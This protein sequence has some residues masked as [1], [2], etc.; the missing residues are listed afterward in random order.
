MNPSPEP[1]PPIGP[2][3][4][5][6]DLI[7][8]PALRAPADLPIGEA[9]R[10]FAGA[11]AGSSPALVVVDG[12]RPIGIVTPT[13]LLPW[14]GADSPD[15][16]QPLSSLM[17]SPLIVLH[18]DA[19]LEAARELL[20]RAHIGRLGVTDADGS[21]VGLV[22]WS[23][24]ATALSGEPET[25]LPSCGATAANPAGDDPDDPG[26]PQVQRP[27][28]R[29]HDL[30]KTTTDLV[31]D[32]DPA[33]HFT[34]VSERARDLLG[35]EP[36]RLIGRSI[37][38][39]MSPAEAQRVGVQFADIVAA[40]R[41][42]R[43]LEN[44]CLHRDGSERVLSTSGVPLHATN[45]RLI[46][47]RGMCRDL[48]AAYRTAQALHDG[49]G[50][51]R[52]IF[53][54]A[55]VG[56]MLLTG[57]RMLERCNERFAEILGYDS[58]DAMRG[59]SMRALHLD[60]DHFAAF[61][62]E[63]YLSLRFGQ[64]R[65]I[66]YQL[67]RADGSPVWCLLSGRAIDTASP[68]DLGLGVIWTVED[69]TERKAREAELLALNARLA[70]DQTLFNEGPAMVFRWR[71]E[72]GWPVAE[73]SPNVERL[74][75][76]SIADLTAGRV[77]FAD[78]LHLD[79]QARVTAEVARHVAAGAAEY[80][81]FYR[82]RG[83]GGQWLHVYDYTRVLRAADGTVRAYHG[84]LVDLTPQR[85]REEE[86]RALMDGIPDLIF[87][88]DD[89]GRYL[90]CNVAFSGFIGRS[91]SDVL[92]HTDQ[93]LFTPAIAE[94]FRAHDRAMLASGLPHRNEEWVIW[95]DGTRHLLDTLKMPYARPGS[96]VA[97]VLGISRDITEH[98]WQTRDLDRAQ[99]LARV[100]SFFI[101]LVA[102]RTHWSPHLYRILGL[103]VADAAPSDARLLTLVLPGDQPHLAETF[104][105]LRRG[106]LEYT[107]LD[108]RIRRPD[109]EV[110]WLTSRRE[111]TRDEHGVPVRIDGVIQDVTAQR[112][113][114]Q[115][116]AE[117]ETRYRTLFEHMAQPL[118]VVDGDGLIAAV[119]PAFSD[120]LGYPQPAALIGAAPGNLSPRCQPDGEA[121][122][123]K[124]ERMVALARAHGVHRFEWVH[125]RRDGTGVP[126]EVTLNPIL[127]GGR[128]V[129]LASVYDLRD[130][131]RA[132][133]WE[134]RAA[135]VFS[136]TTEGILLT[137]AVGRIVAVNPAFTAITG[138]R[139]DEVQGRRPNV[140]QS[141]RQDRG[142]YQA[143]WR[144]LNE[145]G[146]W[147]GQL[148]NRR[149][150]GELFVEWLSISAIRNPAGQVQSYIGIF[151]DITAAE[152]T[153]EEL[154]HLT[155]HD[156]LTDL[157]NATLFRA[158]L[159]QL[160]RTGLAGAQ[161]VAVL[162][163]NLDGFKHVVSA[164]GHRQADAV[165]VQVAQLLRD[166][167]PAD[168]TL[169]RLG[170]DTFAVGI[171][172]VPGPEAVSEHVARIQALL[173]RG[174]RVEGVGTLAIGAGLGVA[175]CPSDSRDATELL[176][177]ADSALVTAKAGGPGAWAFFRPEMTAR[178]GERL[179]LGQALR[180]AL[181][182]GELVLYLQPQLDLSN[183]LV[184]GAEALIRWRTADGV[185][186]LPQDFMPVVESSDLVWP[187]GRRVIQEAARI[188]ADWQSAGL[189]PV[190]I[191]V[192]VS[193]AMIGG[194][195]LADAIVGAAAAFGIDPRLLGIEVLENV[196][197]GNPE[198]ARTEIAAVRS[199]GVAVAL[200]DFG[201]GYSSL[202]YL[203]RFAVD[204]LKI[205]RAFIGDLRPESEDL[206]IVR[207]TISMAHHLGIQ[208]V[209]EGVESTDQLVRLVSLGC[210]F[211]QGHL[212]GQ[213]MPPEAFA[214]LLRQTDLRL[215]DVPVQDL[216]ARRALLVEDD[217]IQRTMLAAFFRDLG[218]R[219]FA[220][221]SA[222][223]ARER[224]V[225]N[226]VHLLIADYRLPGENGVGLLQHARAHYP[227]VVRVL[228]SASDDPEVI[229]EGI[230][231]GGIFYYLPKPCT[232]AQ[233]ADLCEAGFAL[234]RLLRQAG[235]LVASQVQH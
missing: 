126:V 62:K 46:G 157:P 202:A 108:Y 213:P 139:E 152:R 32:V 218:W 44:R 96:D 181:A 156:L 230:N 81:Q 82:L 200:D 135:T 68:A 120:L 105:R 173:H 134:R 72:P 153:A 42:F 201:T 84:Y 21:L 121:S 197:I 39:L 167:L 234:A 19:T 203:K 90:D 164:Y 186:H 124:A 75:G 165:L 95:S 11:A 175:L 231:L 227:E 36:E 136:A 28:A 125:Q 146:R 191:S 87:F 117:S 144:E 225:H 1:S 148:W 141:G 48:T 14:L 18:A 80:E 56:I 111:L 207:S 49:E 204:A 182:K 45:G 149:K 74:L 130:R 206:A 235:P 13:D 100:G 190:P 128:Q 88:K 176:H 58:P 132:E 78:L 109:G 145:T 229:A 53:D 34:F 127:L 198:R 86:L 224:L 22:T 85:R 222:E 114:Q 71:P 115:A 137:D 133:D 38:D 232:R 106:D 76:V 216:L 69:I 209:T 112:L 65:H 107:E 118:V 66:E 205:D 5:L 2:R 60:E 57:Y 217:P 166:Y 221:A 67:R 233:I 17:R 210:D 101:D 162:A 27:L 194:G 89:R 122:G 178:A 189:T 199:L 102:G 172:T 228:I 9:V 119:N 143:M 16:T 7:T 154:E 211:A 54:N 51:L 47:Y 174:L 12:D 10:L 3:P 171:A 150:D 196:L 212:I 226:D 163:L 33:G 73:C 41:P 15:R 116:L 43:D 29:L 170:A 59:L 30:L 79:D 23:A 179:R 110:R 104:Q 192:N 187:V 40:R 91:R 83:A 20:M 151:S 159:D 147:Q 70:E 61:G 4:C 183:G 24:L 25:A 168:A 188:I 55:N 129:L 219:L 195:R 93:E 31:W 99:A 37:F 52:A 97:G 177:F 185:L 77:H 8:G 193:S 140:L 214:D 98:H 6:A 184:A 161:Q 131:R 138:Y 103:E 180:A 35:Y 94:L 142:F 113:A 155:H 220:V 223:E 92:G 160:M 123:L 63:H 64:R 158:R 50:Q 208:V 215:G 169:A 26:L